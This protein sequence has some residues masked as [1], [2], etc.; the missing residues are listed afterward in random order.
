MKRLGGVALIAAVL[1]LAG[2]AAPEPAPTVTVTVT[3][4][5]APAPTVTV[6]V[7]PAE[8][9][10]GAAT[11]DRDAFLA[12]LT[13]IDPGLTINADRAVSRADDICLDIEQDKTDEQLVRNTELR[14]EGGDVPDLSVD[15][16]REI[17]D[18]ARSYHC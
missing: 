11:P 9:E 5:P 6:T 17:V 10:S 18:A 4:T 13:A 1:M 14:F 15:Q 16:A 7:A 8:A 12:A 2:C 3:E